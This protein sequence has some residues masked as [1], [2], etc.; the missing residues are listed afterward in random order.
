MTT[1]KAPHVTGPV[2]FLGPHGTITEVALKF[3]LPDADSVSADSVISALDMVRTGAAVAAVV[4]IENSVEGS[5]S[6]T[7]DSLSSGESLVITAEVSIPVRFALLVQ[8]GTAL[9]DVY[10]VATHPH[11]QAQCL[12]WL[13]SQLPQAK[14]IPATSTADAAAVL[15]HITNVL[16]GPFNAAIAQ[17]LAAAHYGLD[18]VADNIGDNAEA[19]TRFVMVQKSGSLPPSTGADKTTLAVFM[20]QDHPGALLEILTELA[21]RGVNMTRIESRPTRKA[22]GDYFF[23]ID[24]EGHIDDDRVREA[25]MGLHRICGDVRFLGS[26]ARDDGHAPLL[27]PGVL[28]ADFDG[29]QVWL[30]NIRGGLNGEQGE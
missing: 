19:L 4:P 8:P 6:T 2:S 28:N 5:V 22:M 16:A 17:P 20:K 30:S 12:G 25:L 23:S 1:A 26:Y 15:A 9:S 7:L 27:R 24:C 18:V 11:A 10:A 29:A 14:L 3:L 13:R 21:V